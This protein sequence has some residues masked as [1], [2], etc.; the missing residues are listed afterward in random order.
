MFRR[1]RRDL[2]I[3]VG[4]SLIGA[5]LLVAIALWPTW[6]ARRRLV[7]NAPDVKFWCLHF[8][9]LARTK[10]DTLAVDAT[11]PSDWAGS[12]NPPRCG[13][14]RVGGLLDTTAP[15]APVRYCPLN[16]RGPIRI[17]EDSIG[18]LPLG[19]VLRRLR[20]TCPAARETVHYDEAALAFPFPGLTATAVQS[21]DSLQLGLPADIW[22]AEGPTGLLPND[23]PMTA[24]WA[25]LRK[26][27]GPGR[28]ARGE[29]AVTAMFCAHPRLF[30]TLSAPPETVDFSGPEVDLSLVPDSATMRDVW[31]HNTPEPE[32][33]WR[34]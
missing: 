11:P 25:D 8:Y 26:A 19:A 22:I 1:R 23:V 30:F 34:C 28:I 6:P 21:R 4:G 20:E 32:P 12:D 27:Y 15:S 31:I 18:T 17:S 13:E 33:G 9:G 3:A 14:L 2:V 7:T 16:A 5:G 29:T 24:R 10:S